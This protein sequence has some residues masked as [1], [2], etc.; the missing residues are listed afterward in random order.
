MLKIPCILFIDL[1]GHYENCVLNC[2]EV[3]EVDHGLVHHGGL[4]HLVLLQQ[5][6]QVVDNELGVVSHRYHGHHDL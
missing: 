1:I 6:D 2:D 4:G 3:C 5:L